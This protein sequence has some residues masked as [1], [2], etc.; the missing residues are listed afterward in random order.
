MLKLCRRQYYRRLDSPVTDAELAEAYRADALFEAHRDDPEFGYRYLREEA[1][2]PGEA[3][4]ARTAW[5]ICSQNAWWSAF[6]KEKTTHGKKP[7]PPAHDDLV[8]RNFTA[9]APNE[10]WLGDI[11]E[12]RTDE[13][14]LYLCAIKDVYSGR[15]VGSNGP[16]IDVDDGPA[17]GDSP[18]SSSKRSTPHRPRPRPDTT[19]VTRPCSGPGFVLRQWLVVQPFVTRIDSAGVVFALADVQ[20]EMDRLGAVGQVVHRSSC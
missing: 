8:Q 6:G 16:T 15:I 2:D 10:L 13:G 3:M 18:R 4:S 1:T 14:K 7:G 17:W 5:R 19:S 11:P 12:H 20:T 9:Q